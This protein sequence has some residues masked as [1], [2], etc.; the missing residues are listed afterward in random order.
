M[1]QILYKDVF[2]TFLEWGD[3]RDIPMIRCIKVGFSFVNCR[4]LEWSISLSYACPG[5]S[6]HELLSQSQHSCY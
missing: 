2:L 5:V 1:G 3:L 4:T 6:H